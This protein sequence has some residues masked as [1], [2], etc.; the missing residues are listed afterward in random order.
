MLKL[1]HYEL[2]HYELPH[3]ELLHY[4]LLQDELLHYE[5]LHPGQSRFP[6]EL[7]TAAW[8]SVTLLDPVCCFPEFIGAMR[9][10]SSALTLRSSEE[11]IHCSAD[12]SRKCVL[13]PFPSRRHGLK[14]GRQ[15][16]WPNSRPTITEDIA[17]TI[18]VL[19]KPKLYIQ[20]KCY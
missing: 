5:L 1:P 6:V 11:L 10:M 12:G 16:P 13:R 18:K 2:P 8:Y 15:T 19:I 20:I 17:N 3:Y 4:E 9:D 14:H 7:I